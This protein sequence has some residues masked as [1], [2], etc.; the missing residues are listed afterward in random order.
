VLEDPWEGSPFVETAMRGLHGRLLAAC[1]TNL[2]LAAC[3]AGLHLAAAC[4]AGWR[5]ILLHCMT[6]YTS[7]KIGAC[8]P[9]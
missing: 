8:T 5:S 3:P 6:K 7:F 4:W 2:H 9:W 1:A